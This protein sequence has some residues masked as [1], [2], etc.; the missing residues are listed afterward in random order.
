LVYLEDTIF[1]MFDGDLNTRKSTKIITKVSFTISLSG[2]EYCLKYWEDYKH[3]TSQL[4]TQAL[5]ILKVT[6]ITHSE[7]FKPL[8]NSD[9]E[10]IQ[11]LKSW[12]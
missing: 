11:T 5:F 6:Q 9:G 7:N 10:R 2:K 3:L 4:Y 1:Y 8:Y 12:L